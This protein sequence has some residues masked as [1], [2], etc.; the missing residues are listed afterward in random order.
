VG[1]Q[2]S[3][4]DRRVLLHRSGR[5]ACQVVAG[6]DI[7]TQTMSGREGWAST[8]TR[9]RQTTSDIWSISSR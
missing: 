1:L 4:P 8:W 5:R 6:A 2:L 7:E 3:H 9:S